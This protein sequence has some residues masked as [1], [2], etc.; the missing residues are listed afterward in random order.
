MTRALLVLL[1]L[2]WA[3][4][5][6]AG[7][8]CRRAVHLD[9]GAVAPCSGDLLPTSEVLR[10][11]L[12]E[13]AL[14]LARADLATDRELAA[15]AQDEATQMLEVERAARRDCETR[16]APPPPRPARWYQSPWFSAVVGA[17]VGSA[18][19]LGAVF[20]TE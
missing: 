1:L 6:R 14:E 8:P 19:V 10:L 15:L 5:A 2:A 18:I 17:V 12:I 13:D 4:S 11:L 7:E 20:A 9:A 3:P 16:A